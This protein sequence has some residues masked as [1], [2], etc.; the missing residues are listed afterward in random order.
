MTGRIPEEKIQEIRERTDIVEVVSGYLPLK[1]SGA[2]HQGLCPFHGEKTPS[3]NVN[4]TRQIFHCFGCGVGG[5]VFAFLMQIEGL[6]F[7]EAVRRL[8]ERVGV[9]IPEE[10]PSPA[11]L[12]RREEEERLIRINEVACEFYHHIL[13]EAPEGAAARSYLRQRGYDGETARRFRLGYAP[14]SWDAL[15][16]HLATKGFDAELVRDRLGLLRAGR[17]GRSDIDLFRRRLLFPIFDLR[18]QVVAFGGRV[19]DDALPKYINSPESP[20]YHKGR[21]LFGLYQAREAMRREGAGIVVEGYFD[22]L[23]LVRAGFENVVASCGTALTEDHARLLKRYCDKLLLLFDQ[24]SAGQKA[25]F[26][27]MDVLLATGL[28]TEVVPLAAGEDPDS[29]LARHGVEKFRD[30]LAAARPVL[31]VFIDHTLA[32]EASDIAGQ[33]RAV[34]LI[35]GKLRLLPSEIERSLYLQNL[36]RRT[37][38]DAGLL[39]R[40]LGA[41]PPRRAQPVSPRP[42]AAP[43]GTAPPRRRQLAA[44]PG[45]KSQDWLLNL[46][47]AEPTIRSQVASEG[48]ESFFADDD[49]RAIAE[50]ILALGSETDA[51]EASRLGDSLTAA[52]NALLSGILV[53]DEKAFDED[54]EA[55][56]AGCRKATGRERLKQRSRAVMAEIQE[57]QLQGDLQRQNELNRELIAINKQLKTLPRV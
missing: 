53:K 49:R 56:F 18:G 38:L 36:A 42:V 34:E 57:A 1:R 8:G 41:E 12:R 37:G 47:I 13:L 11:E 28:S 48:V 2:N 23:A 26:R 29:F 46:M 21:T 16:R 52:Q 14:E 5:N 39:A 17:E 9:E 3:F 10:A 25:T 55:I 27:A 6:S 20:I 32:G 40:K 45:E 50:R 7:P 22:Q 30:R 44:D 24:D 33:A 35:L 51:I 43:V 4:S 19:L 54:P 15:A 31:E